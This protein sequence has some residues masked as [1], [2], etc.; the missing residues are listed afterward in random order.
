APMPVEHLSTLDDPRVAIYRHVA[1][2]ELV[3]SR[4]LF[5]A[6]G[7]LVVRRLIEEGRYSIQSVLV[8]EP[9]LRSLEDALG[10]IADRVPIYVCHGRDFVE[11]TGH[12][13]H[14]GCLAM[15]E[16]PPAR[17]LADLFPLSSPSITENAPESV[18]VG[19][20][21]GATILVLE[22]LANA[23]NVGG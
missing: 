8:N 12:R 11:M 22:G 3:R 13:I 1:E 14:R 21:G 23:D 5:I 20:A 18:G 7:R 16:R 4:G 17:S 15:V 6:E 2:P 10:A 19:A 9:A